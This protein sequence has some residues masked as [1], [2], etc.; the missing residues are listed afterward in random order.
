MTCEDLWPEPLRDAAPYRGRDLT[1]LAADVDALL[2]A[3]GGNTATT[4][5]GG[6]GS[7]ASSAN[8]APA[9]AGVYS[10]LESP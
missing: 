7:A 4:S 10:L 1:E 5:T 3:C 2:A 6:G 8:T 9:I